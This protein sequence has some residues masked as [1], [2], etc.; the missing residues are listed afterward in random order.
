MDLSQK[1][2]ENWKLLIKMLINITICLL[3]VILENKI[4][5]YADMQRDVKQISGLY[6]IENY[7]HGL[8]YHEIR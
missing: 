2:N 1:R 6:I 8:H 5:M 4:I 7:F 3:T